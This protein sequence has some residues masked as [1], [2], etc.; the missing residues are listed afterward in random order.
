MARDAIA[1]QY[2][3]DKNSVILFC[4][5]DKGEYRPG[6]I[7]SH[8]KKG[9]SVDLEKVRESIAATRL[10]GGTNMR[11]VSLEITARGEVVADGQGL[12]LKAPGTRQEFVLA[13]N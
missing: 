1:R 5:A 8:A 3:V 2:D 10:S 13:E 11:V 6:T 7:I 9:R 12:L 4:E